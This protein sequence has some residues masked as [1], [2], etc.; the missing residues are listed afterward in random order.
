M[1]RNELFGCVH[2]DSTSELL[3]YVDKFTKDDTVPP[4]IPLF[5]LPTLSSNGMWQISSRR[6][7]Q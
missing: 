4:Q 3:K 5:V 1:Q 7:L 6:L 2:T